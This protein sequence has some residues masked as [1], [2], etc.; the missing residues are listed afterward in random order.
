[1]QLATQPNG[2]R[3]AVDAFSTLG[4]FDFNP[5][6][7]Q[8]QTSPHKRARLLSPPC[9]LT[10]EC[11]WS[12]VTTD[13]QYQLSTT[14]AIS[15]PCAPLVSF[16]GYYNPFEGKG[17]AACLLSTVSASASGRDVPSIRARPVQSSDTGK[18]TPIKKW[19]LEG[20]CSRQPSPSNSNKNTH[21]WAP[22]RRPRRR[23]FPGENASHLATTWGETTSSRGAENT[24][25]GRSQEQLT[26]VTASTPSVSSSGSMTDALEFY[27]YCNITSRRSSSALNL[28]FIEEQ[29]KANCTGPG[30]KIAYHEN[31]PSIT[32]V[33]QECRATSIDFEISSTEPVMASNWLIHPAD[34]SLSNIFDDSSVIEGPLEGIGSMSH[35]AKNTSSFQIPPADTF[36]CFTD[37]TSA[38]FDFLPPQKTTQQPPTHE[39]EARGNL[40]R[41][42]NHLGTQGT[43]LKIFRPAN[44]DRLTMG[45]PFQN[46]MGL[47]YADFWGVPSFDGWQVV[48]REL[49]LS[50][51]ALSTLQAG[52]CNFPLLP[53]VPKEQPL[54]RSSNP[55]SKKPP[56]DAA[57]RLLEAIQSHENFD[58]SSAKEY[59]SLPLQNLR[60]T[61]AVGKPLA[62]SRFT[63][64]DLNTSEKNESPLLVIVEDTNDT[65]QEVQEFLAKANQPSK[66]R[67]SRSSN[68]SS[69]REVATT[70]QHTFVPKT[71][72]TEA[73]RE[74]PPK[75]TAQKLVG[76]T[77]P[78][79]V[80]AR[81]KAKEMRKI[82]SCLRCKVS[83]IAC[84][85]GEICEPCLK[86]QSPSFPNK[87]CFRA[88][89]KDYLNLFLPEQ[90]VRPFQRASIDQLVGKN[91][92]GYGDNRFKVSLSSGPC[93]P[94]I[95]VTVGRFRTKDWC[96]P[97]FSAVKK[98]VSVDKSKK[99][100]FVEFYSPPFGIT[101]FNQDLEGKLTSHIQVIAKGERNYGEVLYGNTSGLTWDLY[102]ADQL[103]R[104]ALILYAMQFFMTKTIVLL[105]EESEDALEHLSVPNELN[106]RRPNLRMINI[107]LKHVM[108]H[109]IRDAYAEVLEK[110]EK[111]LRPKELKLWAPTFC[112]ILIL[113]M[114]A[115]MV[116]VTSDHRV[117]CALDDMSKSRDGKD[118]NGNEASRDASFDICRKLDDLPIASAESSFHVIYKTIKLKDG[119]GPKREHGFNP[120]RDGLDAVRKAKLGADVEEFV[121][122]IRDVVAKHSEYARAKRSNGY[123]H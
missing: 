23:P 83:K 30:E 46:N 54:E 16:P 47:G 120:I 70:W 29:L 86:V 112:C 90:A 68:D 42:D 71:H 35:D 17:D 85:Q 64:P 21:G 45:P 10:D 9:Y 62:S 103:L 105:R 11:S 95:Q 59:S 2:K 107:Q 110:L 12:T 24:I 101:D 109:L 113:C 58:E 87:I 49:P 106:M 51:M 81:T 33:D 77:R 63:I 34:P 18:G 91:I 4:T 38:S 98:I 97:N 41:E 8:N 66:A 43:Q 104:K 26:L 121:G 40:E 50:S 52:P 65:Q 117:V 114:C 79:S 13:D 100:R 75:R 32:E 116:Q 72:F 25:S 115:E 92:S 39:L 89:L 27:D 44:S 22:R 94:P 57:I 7:L 31:D 78:L 48:E 60:E 55:H 56:I 69:T 82:R 108:L 73:G 61:P 5:G 28:N 15:F 20:S 19:D 119:P 36:E 123:R 88:H 53:A 37:F 1:M 96:D 118:K 111:D 122:R 67:N 14:A 80:D 6:G 102:E 93:Y 84:T 99:L 76:R 3:S 74:S